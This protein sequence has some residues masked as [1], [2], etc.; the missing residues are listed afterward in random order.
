M[1]FE[2]ALVRLDDGRRLSAAENPPLHNSREPIGS[3]PNWGRPV[4]ALPARPSSWR[5]GSPL[6]PRVPPSFSC[7]AAP[8][9]QWLDW[10]P[11]PRRSA[12]R[13]AG[14][15]TRYPGSARA[16]QTP[17]PPPGMTESWPGALPR[18]RG[19]P[20]TAPVSPAVRDPPPRPARQ[21]RSRRAAPG[22]RARCRQYGQPVELPLRVSEHE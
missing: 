2:H 17:K 9:W 12:L 22:S 8:S 21:C 5:C 7:S 1:P 16:A 14:R 15:P 10:S 3:S 13:A 19:S 18:G 4:R 11:H 20:R 6:W